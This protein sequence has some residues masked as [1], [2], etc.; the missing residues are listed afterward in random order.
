[1]EEF[2]KAR[3][4]VLESLGRDSL[5]AQL[6]LA[7]KAGVK[8]A[9]ILGQREALDETIVVRR[10]ETGHQKE[11]KLDKIVKEVKKILKK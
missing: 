9:L 2:R 5:K 11:V 6:K 7:D 4:P 8:Y 10:M 3:I 1:M